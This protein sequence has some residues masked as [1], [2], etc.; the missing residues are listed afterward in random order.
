[1]Q[2]IIE[3]A[4]L[5]LKFGDDNLLDHFKDRF[6]EPIRVAEPVAGRGETKQ[7]FLYKTE[8]EMVDGNPVMHGRFVKIQRIEAEQDFDEKRGLLVKS[9]ETMRSAPSAYFLLDLSSHR[10]AFLHEKKRS[11]SLGNFEYL[12]SRILSKDWSINYR[13]Y[14]TEWLKKNRLDHVSRSK[15]MKW[16]YILR[17]F[18]LVPTLGLRRYQR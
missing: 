15:K 12:I 18:F 14:K 3:L 10:L 2:K 7:Y 13:R 11:P 17:K 16:N 1:M 6:W 5:V 9:D 8:I 4:N